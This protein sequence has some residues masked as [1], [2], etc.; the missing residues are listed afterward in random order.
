VTTANVDGVKAEVDGVIE[1]LGG[2]RVP[3]RRVD[4]GGLPGYA[5]RVRLGSPSGGVSRL[6]VLAP[7]TRCCA[8]SNGPSTGANGCQKPSGAAAT[9][10]S[11]VRRRPLCLAGL[12]LAA[13]FAVAGC[14]GGGDKT[15]DADQIGVKFKYSPRFH[16]IEDIDFGQSAGAEAVAQAGVALDKV[17]AI[18]LS[19]YDLNATIDKDNLAKFKGEV[20]DVISQLAG[21][22]VSGRE[23]EYGGLPG[24]EYV[25][26]VKNPAQG[27]SRMAV[28]FDQATEYL[29]NCQSTPPD[30]DDI[31]AGCR[32]ALDTLEKK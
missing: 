4:F 17:N 5:Y 3:G 8:R 7:A 1:N 31:E 14:G 11:M 24:Y 26:D 21:H 15:F 27:Q 29:I 16:P 12:V 2:K 19:R 30:R 10:K 32:K 20:D 23:V 28:L 22:R 13:A 25:I 18:I 9:F 6:Y